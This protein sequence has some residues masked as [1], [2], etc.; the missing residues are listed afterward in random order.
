MNQQTSPTVTGVPPVFVS[1]AFK[2]SQGNSPAERA[3]FWKMQN[4]S[5]AFAGELA[6]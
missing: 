5:V 4:N 3:L 1:K 6:G 2:D